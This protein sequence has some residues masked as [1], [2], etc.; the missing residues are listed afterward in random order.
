MDSSRTEVGVAL[1]VLGMTTVPDNA[2]GRVAIFTVDAGE[3][4]RVFVVDVNHSTINASNASFTDTRTHLIFSA[5]SA[6]FGNV[7]ITGINENPILGVRQTPIATNAFLWDN[8][9]QLNMWGVVYIE[10]SGTGF[11][12]EFIGDAQDSSIN[13]MGS[14]DTALVP[15]SP[16]ADGLHIKQRGRG[17]N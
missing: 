9:A 1:E 11:A 10:A 12:M 5:A 4:H 15:L 7:R 8:V 13:M 2:A 3:T 6:E 14:E 17:I 16:T